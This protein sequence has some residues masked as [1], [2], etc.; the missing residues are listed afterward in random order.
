M[1]VNLKCPAEYS[2]VNKENTP[3]SKC[4]SRVHFIGITEKENSLNCSWCGHKID[5]IHPEIMRLI[6]I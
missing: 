3:C 5:E 2:D 6:R 1:T 4:G